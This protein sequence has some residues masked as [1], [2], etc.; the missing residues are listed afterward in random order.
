MIKPNATA[1]QNPLHEIDEITREFK[2]T[3]PAKLA[4]IEQHINTLRYRYHEN[5]AEELIRTLH[6]FVGSSGTFGL[7]ELCSRMREFEQQ[8]IEFRARGKLDKRQTD[9]IWSHFFGVR[10]SLQRSLG[11]EI[12]TE[13]PASDSRSAYP[14]NIAIPP[15][16]IL[17]ISDDE[18]FS[19]WMHS[20]LS[21]DKHAL[22]V[23]DRVDGAVAELHKK[24]Y[25]FILSE[26]M[27]AGGSGFE[28]AR[29]VR[30]EIAGCYMPIV[31]ITS[32][33]DDLSKIRAI[34]AGGDA[35]LVKPVSIESIK[36]TL[37]SIRRIIDKARVGS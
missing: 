13:Q 14:S 31:F 1:G 26:V 19:Q 15:S 3:L 17:L 11:E 22:A 27:L 6:S 4:I 29:M 10:S 16:N 33:D 35:V 12:Q 24:Q 36:A 5:T 28:I 32:L 9:R 37:F 7:H 21:I 30:T 25:D 2:K 34:E 18:H 8:F 20:A 23:V